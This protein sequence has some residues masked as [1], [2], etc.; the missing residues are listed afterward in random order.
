[1]KLKHSMLASNSLGD[2][3][4]GAE[5]GISELFLV[6][7]IAK[8][9]AKHTLVVDSPTASMREPSG[10][11]KK[12]V[13]VITPFPRVEAK[14]DLGIVPLLSHKKALGLLNSAWGA[15]GKSSFFSFG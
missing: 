4:M 3:L 5:V 14:L 2:F 13:H 12:T 6:M 11:F 15:L 10:A 8:L 1:V 7:L 9:S